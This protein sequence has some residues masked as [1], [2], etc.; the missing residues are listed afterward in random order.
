MAKLSRATIDAASEQENASL[1]R[2]V[3]LR[4]IEE[5]QQPRQQVLLPTVQDVGILNYHG[6]KTFG[7]KVFAV[8]EDGVRFSW[9]E[10]DAHTRAET[11]LSV[12]LTLV[13][14][15]KAGESYNWLSPDSVLTTTSGA[16][17]LDRFSS[18]IDLD[19]LA[20]EIVEDSA[21]GPAADVYAFAKLVQDALPEVA[22]SGNPWAIAPM[23]RG[24]IDS[25]LEDVRSYIRPPLDEASFSSNAVSRQSTTS[26]SEGRLG[27]VIRFPA[28]R[29]V[30]IGLV[31]VIAAGVIATNQSQ[32]FSYGI[33]ILRTE[34]PSAS[35]KYFSDYVFA[36]DV[37]AENESEAI[38]RS[39]AKKG[40]EWELI[41][42]AFTALRA[43]DHERAESICQ[44]LLA[45]R[46][47]DDH[48]VRGEAHYI[49]ATIH[50]FSNP[51]LADRHFQDAIE[52]YLVTGHQEGL[53]RASIGLAQMKIQGGDPAMGEHYLDQAELYAASADA[54]VDL[55]DA[56]FWYY[57]IR[58][59]LEEEYG[60][61]QAA[62]EWA[63]KRLD[64]AGDA[65]GDRAASLSGLAYLQLKTGLFRE[66]LRN[67]REAEALAFKTEDQQIYHYNLINEIMVNNCLGLENDF[68]VEELWSYIEE[69]QDPNLEN[70]LKEALA[71]DCEYIKKKADPLNV[72]PPKPPPKSDS[73]QG[74]GDPPQN[75]PA[76]QG[77]GG[78]L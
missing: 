12:G 49:L 23:D 41:G 15:H 33:D 56:D 14:L 63:Q 19:Y 70:A 68:I 3:V 9:D 53:Y 5:N 64:A 75:P 65:A 78:L 73:Q 62:L 45:S 28:R 40:G 58:K 11:L 27:R 72:A 34:G 35:M 71:F 55:S 43:L 10:A 76:S 4:C 60:N 25:L 38:D 8:V 16:I 2:T 74:Q 67:T 22:L 59:A 52:D 61:D 77:A 1:G 37:D 24:A 17:K 54:D 36:E 51:A 13:R 18:G 39:V 46:P 29:Y 31:S 69:Y 57:G 66:G 26:S 30:L 50:M 47:K 7:P 20:P 44:K 6:D 32:E 21:F 48:E 42:Y